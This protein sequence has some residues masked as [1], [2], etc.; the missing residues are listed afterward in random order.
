VL[1][2]DDEQDIG[3]DQQSIVISATADTHKRISS[4][5]FFFFFFVLKHITEITASTSF[6]G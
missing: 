5:F 4:S 1:L 3:A 6:N 2:S